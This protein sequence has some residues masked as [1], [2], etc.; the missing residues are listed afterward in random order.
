MPHVDLVIEITDKD[1]KN[2]CQAGI[3]SGLF[4][5][6]NLKASSPEGNSGRE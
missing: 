4:W 2:I 6:Y 3:P 1:P 5:H